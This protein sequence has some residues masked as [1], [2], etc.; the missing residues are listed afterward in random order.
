MPL[1]LL[2]ELAEIFLLV[3]GSRNLL[4]SLKEYKL[5]VVESKGVSVLSKEEV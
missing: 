2:P 5:I 1:C 3:L 4:L